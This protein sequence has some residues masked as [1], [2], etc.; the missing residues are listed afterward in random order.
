M[1]GIGNIQNVHLKFAIMFC[2]SFNSK[3]SLNFDLLS[4]YNSSVLNYKETHPFP[5]KNTI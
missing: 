3:L 5:I 2:F 1:V 4:R